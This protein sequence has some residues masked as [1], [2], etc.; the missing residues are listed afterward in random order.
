MR[1]LLALR[2]WRDPGLAYTWTRAWRAAGPSVDIPP[3]PSSPVKFSG[4]IERDWAFDRRDRLP[5]SDRLW[6][7]TL[8]LLRR[9]RKFHLKTSLNNLRSPHSISSSR[10]MLQV[11]LKP[12]KMRSFNL[13]LELKWIF[14]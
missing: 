13:M 9:A 14:E 10:A 1:L 5:R 2:L 11:R 6:N 4:L 12:L 8:L 3:L 7:G